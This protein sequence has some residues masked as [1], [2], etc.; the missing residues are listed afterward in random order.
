MP[1]HKPREA[2]K[3]NATK[4]AKSIEKSPTVFNQT[5]RKNVEVILKEIEEDEI[6]EIFTDENGG[7]SE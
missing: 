1:N 2:H 4:L 7:A 3:F 5:I 6:V